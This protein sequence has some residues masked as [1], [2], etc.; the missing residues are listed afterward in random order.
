M[1][2]PSLYTPL[3]HGCTYD[4]RNGKIAVSDRANH[5]IEYFDYDG[6]DPSKFT[7]SS[8]VDMRPYLG[9][10]TLPCNLRMYPDQKGLS[11]SPDLQGPVAV[12]D[13]S[14]A[15]VSVVNATPEIV[16]HF[17]YQP[18]QCRRRRRN[19]QTFLL[20]LYM[21]LNLSIH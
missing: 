18:S 9:P 20:Y 5:R 7:Y 16:G 12:L 11:I 6:N 3:Q 14:N 21:P 1:L 17:S 2:P 19:R 13:D 15:V 4:P 8:T 10:T